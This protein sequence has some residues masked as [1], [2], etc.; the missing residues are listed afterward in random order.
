MQTFSP[1]TAVRRRLCEALFPVHKALLSKTLFKRKEFRAC[2]HGGWG[3]QVGEVTR[4]AVVEK[5][6]AFT[7]KRTTRGRRGSRK[8]FDRFTAKRAPE[9]QAPRGPGRAPP[10]NFLILTT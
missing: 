10:G 7:C 3:S 1:A 4:L 6:P 5:W 2:L 8:N 9:A